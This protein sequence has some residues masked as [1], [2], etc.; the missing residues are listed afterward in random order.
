MIFRRTFVLA[1]FVL[2][3]I[4]VLKFWITKN[5]Q[6]NNNEYKKI[7][8]GHQKETLNNVQ[9]HLVAT[10]RSRRNNSVDKTK[11]DDVFI[12]IKTS[13]KFHKTRL[14]I[15]V[16]TW[17]PDAINQV[18][19]FTDADDTTLKKRFPSNHVINTNCP[20]G[21]TNL[22]LN[23]KMAWEFEVYLKENNRWFCHFDDDNYVNLP[24]LVALLQNYNHSDDWYLGKPSLNHQIR[25]SD[26][27]YPGQRRAFWFATGGAGFCIS[28]GL[29]R[30]MNV[31]DAGFI[32]FSHR[33]MN[34]SDDVTV[35][36]LI[37]NILHTNLTVIHT[38]YSHLD[39]H[40][41]NHTRLHDIKEA[42]TLSY[43]VLGG[44]SGV[45]KIPGFSFEHDPTRFYSIHC[46]LKQHTPCINNTAFWYNKP[47]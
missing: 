6:I 45:V 22:G 28:K 3:C 46:F 23:C 5:D 26:R 36:Y 24:N 33:T 31:T 39:K 37:N 25:A 9:S 10:D 11:M 8:H 34:M 47:M 27:L 12:S 14:E 30:K 41:T 19:V 21:H 18:Y 40:F 38:F 4:S 1:L 2:G 17:I 16:N 29:A 43:R 42:I 35:G 20:M 13:A 32:K 7:V 44:R 15:L